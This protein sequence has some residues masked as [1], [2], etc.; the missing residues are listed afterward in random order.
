[1][2]YIDFHAHIFPDKVA[3]KAL[4]KLASFAGITPFTEGT[5]SD[6]KTKMESR[7]INR[8]VCLNIATN[9]GQET[10][11]NKTAA[12]VT[13]EH[14]GKI[15]SLGSVHP[16]SSDWEEQLEQIKAYG[17]PGIKLHPDY[18]NFRIEE[19][20][21]YPVYE[22]CAELGLFIV[23]HAG[24][25]CYSP[26]FVHANPDC[27]AKVAKD[28]PNLKMILAHFG[29]LRMWEQ[30]RDNL[31]GLENVYFDTAMC[32]TY[33]LDKTMMADMVKNHPQEN[34]F[35]G[36]DC[37]WEDPGE[38]VKYVHSLPISDDAKERIFY[39]NALNFLGWN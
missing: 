16:E 9:P 31:V 35:L 2:E 28:I 26:N 7:N 24:W 12:E 30:V 3:P 22:K 8:F 4:G 19:K 20:R 27:S 33:E 29:G 17:L 39:Q 15:L 37:P 1:M 6:T 21:I 13:K 10:T 25:D 14:P 23:F 32:A 38:S 5:L 36:S 18:Q 34:V 11:I